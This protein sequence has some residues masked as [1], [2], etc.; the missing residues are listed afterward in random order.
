[1]KNLRVFYVDTGRT[2]HKHRINPA[3]EIGRNTVRYN[4]STEALNMSETS[5]YGNLY[6]GV[7][8]ILS[9]DGE[10]YLHAESVIVAQDGSLVF[11]GNKGQFNLALAPGQWT[12]V[13]AASVMDG[14]A[15]AVDHWD[16]AAR[17]LTGN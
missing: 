12:A 10:I 8:S 4:G 16:D 5:R 2:S 7:K 15:V 1:V 9:D 3:V 11:M 14:S 6:W 17:N 13:F